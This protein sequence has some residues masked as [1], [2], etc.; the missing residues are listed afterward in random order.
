LAGKSWLARKKKSLLF[1]K[2]GKKWAKNRQKMGKICFE[3]KN[4]VQL[5]EGSE[6]FSFSLPQ[7]F[8]GKFFSKS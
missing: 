6:F 1:P 8:V 2:M 5:K 3:K 7:V 4:S